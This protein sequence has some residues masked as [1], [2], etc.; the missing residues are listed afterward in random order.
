[1]HIYT[2]T[3]CF[4][5]YAKLDFIS[6]LNIKFVVWARGTQKVGLAFGLSVFINMLYLVVKKFITKK[7]KPQVCTTLKSIEPNTNDGA[8]KCFLKIRRY[9]VSSFKND[10][11]FD[12]A[13]AHLQALFT[14]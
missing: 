5:N 13:C 14:I 7:K 6:S 3:E 8:R 2:P 1:M 10:T 9:I 11:M 4:K 12:K